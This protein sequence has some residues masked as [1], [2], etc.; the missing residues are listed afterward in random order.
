MRTRRQV[1]GQEGAALQL[2]KQVRLAAGTAV[3]LITTLACGSTPTEPAATSELPPA[4][5]THELLESEPG[6]DAPTVLAVD[7]EDVIVITTSDDGVITGFAADDNGSFVRGKQ[8][9]TGIDYL[10]L[11]G[12]ALLDQRWIAVGT[13]GFDENEDFLFEV[14]AFSSKDGHTWSMTATTPIDG[15]AELAGTAAVDGGVVA[16]GTMRGATI[17]VAW[18]STDGETWTR[19]PLPMG[20]AA[21]GSV[22]DIEAAGDTVLAVGFLG[23]QGAMW[24]SE[25]AGATWAI[26]EGAGI[27]PGSGLSEIA[28]QGAVVVA[29]G[30][31][32]DA[33]S[34]YE[35]TQIL[36][37]SV[38]GG[39]S[40]REVD[41]PPPPNP[42]EAFA[43]S[44]SVGGGGFFGL[45][46]SFIRS[47]TKPEICYADIDLCRQDTAIA[48]YRSADGNR[49]SLVDT[50]AIGEGDDG[51]LDAI[52][53]TDSGRI[54][55]LRR[56]RR[57]ETAWSWPA[58]TPLPTTEAAAD[59]TSDVVLLG[60]GQTPEL[61]RRY[62]VPLYIHCGM[63]WLYVGNT[64]W[65]RTGTGA[66]V[67]TG[68]GDEIPDDW[69][70]AQQTIFGFVTLVEDERIEYSLADGEVIATYEPATEQP[71]GCA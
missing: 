20:G 19:V 56:G 7:G 55:A 36:V 27:P 14:R 66:N 25:D 59:P 12:A 41:A 6:A 68:A 4:A 48:L 43:L 21:E 63:E 22:A 60:E 69:P 37:R 67:E 29:S 52:V 65:Q 26:I 28:A 42:G 39:R 32:Q 13:G 15:P 62:G 44:L 31:R 1:A 18:R 64:P 34:P 61:G 2:L 35:M 9:A 24:A 71:P 16:A 58:G 33:A 49:W 3:L 70:V 45:R 47:W 11:G 53:A 5:W 10:W 54:V 23:A 30:T 51:E 8:T 46:S 40:W 50:T 17:P 38:D 57:G